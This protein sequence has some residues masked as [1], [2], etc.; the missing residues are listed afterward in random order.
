ME[1]H[2]HPVGRA[3]RETGVVHHVDHRTLVELQA[4]CE[5]RE[6][7][8]LVEVVGVDVFGDDPPARGHHDPFE[9]HCHRAA[10]QFAA[11][12]VVGQLDAHLDRSVGGVGDERRLAGE[13]R[14]RRTARVIAHRPVRHGRCRRFRYEPAVADGVDDRGVGRAERR[15]LK[16]E[17]LVAVGCVGRVSGDR[18]SRHG[19]GVDE[20]GLDGVGRHP[21]RRIEPFVDRAAVEQ[22][23]RPL[24]AADL[25]DPVVAGA[26]TD[27]GR[28]AVGLR[29]HR[30]DGRATGLHGE[31][32][33]R[34]VAVAL[35]V[36]RVEGL[37]HH[38]PSD[39]RARRPPDAPRPT[40]VARSR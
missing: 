18:R 13:C 3:A 37:A 8:G 29:G 30:G 11:N 22:A 15:V 23:G 4:R 25:H 20:L 7:D 28:A 5:R 36:E 6:V 31:H 21:T 33:T 35:H 27:R 26:G 38:E 1:G 9:H 16:V 17:E 39:H 10:C 19:V 24:G 40:A 2:L 12:H 14:A 34:H 32:E